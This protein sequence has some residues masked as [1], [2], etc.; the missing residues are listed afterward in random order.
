M[1]NKER[2]KDKLIRELQAKII[3]SNCY[4]DRYSQLIKIEER[5]KPDL[6][7]TFLNLGVEV[8]FATKQKLQHAI[9]KC[10]NP[11]ETDNNRGDNKKKALIDGEFLKCSEKGLAFIAFWQDYHDLLNFFHKKL[12]KLNESHYKC[13]YDAYDLYIKGEIFGID[14]DEI[15]PLLKDMILIQ[16]KQKYKYRYVYVQVLPYIYCFDLKNKIC[17]CKELGCEFCTNLH[18]LVKKEYDLL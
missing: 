5:S 2:N 16:D 15:T 18:S 8:V 14:T 13:N 1:H 12:K 6:F 4:K 10:E 17:E 3:L 7:D 11:K 9:D